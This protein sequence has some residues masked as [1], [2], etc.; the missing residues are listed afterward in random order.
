MNECVNE[1]THACMSERTNGRTMKRKQKLGSQKRNQARKELAWCGHAAF[2]KL[3][4]G[5]RANSAKCEQQSRGP[6]EAPGPTLRRQKAPS[7]QPG[8]AE[9][10]EAHGCGLWPLHSGAGFQGTF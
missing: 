4:E 2:E 6:E 1:R 3:E 8:A 10:E 5:D 9:A 7:A